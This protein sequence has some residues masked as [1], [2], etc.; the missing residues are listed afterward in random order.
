[1]KCIQGTLLVLLLGCSEGVM[2]KTVSTHLMFQGDAHEAVELY[3]SIFDEFVVGE[4]TFHEEGENEGRLQLARVTFA[5]HDLIIFDS[6]P[7]HNFT[8]TPAMS[9]F[10]EFDEADRLKAVFETLAEGGEVAMP[11]ADYGF[12]PLFGWLQDRYGVSWQLSLK[13]AA[14]EVVP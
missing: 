13:S 8:F 11:L 10:V 14:V 12:S 4:K 9:L 3:D 1:M 5:D 6:P 7:V 2:A